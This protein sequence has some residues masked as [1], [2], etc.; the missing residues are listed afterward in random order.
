MVAKLKRKGL[1]EYIKR[2]KAVREI[3]KKA[4]E[5][6]KAGKIKRAKTFEREVKQIR[7]GI[8]PERLQTIGGTKVKIEV[9]KPDIYEV[10]TAGGTLYA[11]GTLTDIGIA[12]RK[13]E[14]AQKL[15]EE[16]ELRQQNR[17]IK[18]GLAREALRQDFSRLPTFQKTIALDAPIKKKPII[19]QKRILQEGIERKTPEGLIIK[20]KPEDIDKAKRLLKSKIIAKSAKKDF[21]KLVENVAISR[22]RQEK[23][24]KQ[25]IQTAQLRLK[26]L[27]NFNKKVDSV[28]RR[29]VKQV[30]DFQEKVSKS[31]FGK[32]FT[33]QNISNFQK[34]TVEETTVLANQFLNPLVVGVNVGAALSAIQPLAKAGLTKKATKKLGKSI[35]GLLSKGGKKLK[36]LK[37]T[38]VKN[39]II[40]SEKN[41]IKLAKKVKK[42]DFTT[43][44]NIAAGIVLFSIFR[45]DKLAIK[46][47]KSLIKLSS[48]TVSNIDVK[49]A[50][51]QF[52]KL[53][54][55]LIA[56]KA[57]KK[58]ISQKKSE[59][60]IRKLKKPKTKAEIRKAE[61]KLKTPQMLKKQEKALRQSEVE[62]KI[63]QSFGKE[64]K[65]IK[66]PTEG[67]FVKKLRGR[68][69][70]FF[71]AEEKAQKKFVLARAR[72]QQ[73]GF[74]R[75]RKAKKS[76][77]S[78]KEIS[79]PVGKGQLV[80]QVV[81]TKAVQTFERLKQPSV[82]QVLKKQKQKVV[83]VGKVFDKK[84]F[85]FRFIQSSKKNKQGVI[86]SQNKTI[87]GF[88]SQQIKEALYRK[89][90]SLKKENVVEANKRRGFVK[91]LNQFIKS[92]KKQ[93]VKKKY[94]T[95]KVE[96]L[97]KTSNIDQVKKYEDKNG[98][99]SYEKALKALDEQISKDSKQKG[100]F[101]DITTKNSKVKLK[102]SLNKIL[103][104]EKSR[105]E[106]LKFISDIKKKP[107]LGFVREITRFSQA[108]V[109]KQPVSKPKISLDIKEKGVSKTDL[110]FITVRKT[111][112][113]ISEVSK[114][115]KKKQIRKKTIVK[116]T[117]KPVKKGGLP[118]KK[119]IKIKKVIRKPK[120][121]FVKLKKLPFKISKK[122]KGKAKIEKKTEKTL[123]LLKYT[124]TL[125]API[126]IKKDKK[127]IKDE[128]LLLFTGL[129]FRG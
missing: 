29:L 39:F 66:T 128:K 50:L 119:I 31:K 30:Y 21:K 4:E 48:K 12:T 103:V 89:A 106:K 86:L 25:A 43:P 71:K 105:N 110:P 5:A 101:D 51:K 120:I 61:V 47:S 97:L 22:E 84:K 36:S 93:K 64:T 91:N 58:T 62:T 67:Q 34:K 124:P 56:S 20:V 126:K 113:V 40:S 41:I 26:R 100:F 74:K 104:V 68:D 60:I 49:E 1:S 87:K 116:K 111:K 42:G 80:K 45:P 35:A 99:G 123:P 76:I 118:P 11:K 90:Q 114:P 108:D 72:L 92:L 85:L 19:P 55:A 75:L 54:K 82:K 98:V 88:R 13:K 59:R 117:I 7:A 79:K 112:K 17:L 69:F 32:P 94:D 81:K 24:E 52:N 83:K 16:R 57:G 37:P 38:E 96:D 78:F 18:R 115:K 14:K 73:E 70:K 28:T 23:K 9:T 44:E 95:K 15:F 33:S 8:S 129:E 107:I 127:V 122:K 6:K 102:N 2:E 121:S 3:R 77:I 53:N 65:G 63:I 10:R 27:E 109:K 125:S 46:G